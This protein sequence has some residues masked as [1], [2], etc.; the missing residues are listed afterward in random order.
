MKLSL[1]KR[2]LRWLQ[3]HPGYHAS[4]DLQRL[5]VAETDYTPRTAV[6]RLEELAEEK[7]IEVEYRKGHAFYSATKP[8]NLPRTDVLP[9]KTTQAEYRT[10]AARMCRLFDENKSPEEIFAK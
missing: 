2:L 6:R 8:Q 5:V 10:M 9:S 7:T 1:E 4:G 3:N